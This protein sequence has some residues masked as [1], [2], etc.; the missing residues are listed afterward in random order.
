MENIF[1]E[2]EKN[3]KY[4][5]DKFSSGK[6]LVVRKFNIQ[7]LECMVVYILGLTNV[8]YVS[9][10]MI[11]P[12][13]EYTG[14]IDKNKSVIDEIIN[15][16]CQVT[17]VTKETKFNTLIS[18]LMKGK[19]LLFVNNSNEAMIMA[20][21]QFKERSIS[22]PPTSAV[23]KGP[24][25]G[26]V[27]NLKTNVSCIR[28]ILG[29]NSL[30]S[31]ILTIG[32]YTNTQVAVLYIEDIANKEVI[33]KVKQKLKKIDIDGVID[34]YYI[35]SFLEEH[36]DS[37]FKQVGTCEKPDIACAKLLEGR[38]AVVV[39]GSPIVLTVPFLLIEDL[40]NS[41]D[42]YSVQTRATMLRILRLIGLFITLLLPGTYIAIV[43]HH[44][45]AI[46][47]KFLIT[48]I[49]TTSGLPLTPFA[50]ILFVLVLFEILY[51]ASLRMPSY[52]GLALSIVGALILGDTA[53]KAGLISPPSVM[54]VAVSGMTLYTIPE[55][56]PQLSILRL[57]F[58]LA[59][60]FLGLFGV[61]ALFIY[62]L[63]YLND[64]DSF[65][66]PY[67]AP[68]SPYIKSDMK[69]AIYKTDLVHMTTRPRSFRVNNVVRLNNYDKNNK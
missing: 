54:L 59:G 21:D 1:F 16:V 2:L 49:N 35:T 18:E 47:L 30:R 43:L 17:E 3:E 24:R 53:V 48:I 36:T 55:Q 4:L 19:C 26:F 51:E 5:L 56:S 37:I 44:Y 68:I 15:K 7:N 57:V 27:E 29:T 52:L 22:E 42:Y 11:K 50:E 64:F 65:G 28:K 31:D 62:F 34:S 9:E 38:V 40:Q 32:K 14:E 25:S 23:L 63:F 8:E 13:L 20:V 12:A 66:A 46:P 60:G 61:V 58:T 67:L 39:D 10:Y 69:D 33:N 6:E 41:D 45:K